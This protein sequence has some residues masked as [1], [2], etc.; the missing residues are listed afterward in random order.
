MSSGPPTSD[1]GLCYPYIHADVGWRR[2][3]SEGLWL[4][5]HPGCRSPGPGLYTSW[6]VFVCYSTTGIRSLTVARE[7]FHFACAG[8]EGCGGTFYSTE[9]ASWPAWHERCRT[10]EHNHPVP[11]QVVKAEPVVVSLPPTRDL[12]FAVRCGQVLYNGLKPALAQYRRFAAAGAAELLA[13]DND[14]KALL[15]AGG[16][17]ELNAEQQA[18]AQ[19]RHLQ[20]QQ[21]HRQEASRKRLAAIQAAQNAVIQTAQNSAPPVAPSPAQAPS[22]QVFSTLTST[23]QASRTQFSRSTVQAPRI[24]F[25]SPPASTV[26]AASAQTTRTP[27]LRRPALQVTPKQPPSQVSP[28]SGPSLLASPVR[29]P[30]SVKRL[31]AIQ[32]VMGRKGK[33]KAKESTPAPLFDS[34]SDEFA[35]VNFGVDLSAFVDPEDRFNPFFENKPADDAHA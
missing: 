13:T 1:S 31:A 23:A 22:A 3:D 9:Q 17:D 6:Y 21:Q 18:I 33:G 7:S 29:S 25:S 30:G 34:D 12:H 4:V 11:L 20:E 14:R 2:E 32:G 16:L 15:F 27:H 35:D 24:Q 19:Q 10:G 26:Q 28:T 8:V 5:T